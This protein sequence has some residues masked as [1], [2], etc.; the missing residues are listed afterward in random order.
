MSVALSGGTAL[1]GADF[2]D[3]VGT[4]SGSA[5]VYD[6]DPVTLI[7]RLADNVLNLNLQQGIENSLDSKLQTVIEALIDVNNNNDV[8]AINALNAFINAVQ[9]QSG[10]KIPVPTHRRCA[11]HHRSAEWIE[12]NDCIAELM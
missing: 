4:N 7:T 8:A 11:G 10:N 12:S 1:V 3:D 5:Y 2:D 6:F 9:A